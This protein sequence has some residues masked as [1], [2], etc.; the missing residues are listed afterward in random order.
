MNKKLDHILITLS[1]ENYHKTQ[2]LFPSN[3]Y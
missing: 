2:F 1:E 3:K